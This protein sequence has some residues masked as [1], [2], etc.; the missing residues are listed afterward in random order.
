MVVVE[1]EEDPIIPTATI[2]RLVDALDDV[3]RVRYP[4]GHFDVYTGAAFERAAARE[5]EFLARHLR[6]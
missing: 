5:A 2:D 6:G 1:T 4:V 3:E